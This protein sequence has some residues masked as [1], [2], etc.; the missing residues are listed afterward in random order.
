M[1]DA[2]RPLSL[3][4]SPR[5]LTLSWRDGA[6]SVAATALRA[7][8][9]CAA[10]QAARLRGAAPAPDPA[11]TLVDAVPMGHYAV[12]LRFSDGHDRG[13]Y[14]WAWLRELA[15]PVGR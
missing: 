9:R 14:P 7:H 4:L 1:N 13:I 12:Q 5:A 8:C 11:V 2:A 10:C 6:A 3:T 15:G